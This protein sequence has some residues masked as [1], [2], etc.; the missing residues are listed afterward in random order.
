MLP[1]EL[2]TGAVYAVTYL[3]G[4]GHDVAPGGVR[5]VRGEKFKKGVKVETADH[6]LATKCIAVGR[7]DVAEAKAKAK[8][9]AKN[10]KK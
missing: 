8:A 4:E 2:P 9:K 7:F 3:G 10:G 1:A 6:K 5:T